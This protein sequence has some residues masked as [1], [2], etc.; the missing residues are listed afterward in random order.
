[1]QPF[2]GWWLW[3]GVSKAVQGVFN[4]TG[5]FEAAS[6]PDPAPKIILEEGYKDRL[7]AD[8]VVKLLI[9]NPELEKIIA[10]I[11]ETKT[12]VF[13][14]QNNI[15]NT[16]NSDVKGVHARIDHLD[17]NLRLELARNSAKFSSE[18]SRCCKR[19]FIHLE[20]YVKKLLV[21]LLGVPNHNQQD[22]LSW[23]HSIFVAKQD[24]ETRLNNVTISMNSNVEA[25]LESS[26]A[27]IMDKVTEKI[28]LMLKQR[29]QNI[30]MNQNI[31]LNSALSD[32]QVHR[33]VK[34]ALAMYDADKTGLVDYALEPSGGQ[35]LSTRCTE[36]YN[37]KTA[38]VSILGIPLWYPSNTPRV[39]ITPGVVPGQCWAF[40][41]FPGFL[42]IELSTYVKVSAFTL[43]HI[44]E[45]LAP[46]GVRDSA[47]KAF[48]VWGL[49]SE[50]DREPWQFGSYAYS[51]NDSSIQYFAVEN[52]APP[53]N[54][55]ELR[56][57]SNHGNL[58]Y[59]C[60]Y[61]FRVHGILSNETT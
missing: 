28:N 18:L 38:V 10:R 58:K 16:L 51:L 37:L 11:I 7:S 39:V 33:I 17:A 48:T 46:G 31:G 47:P 4:S 2:T 34:E 57:E 40:Q 44:P 12:T 35:I 5:Y 22:I 24:L 54:L 1:M 13:Q 45:A 14:E 3:S 42:L 26:A 21:D 53:V 32:S 60:L 20:T 27:R 8:D 56:I 19:Q 25:M 49:K 15:L 55:V 30:E 6:I 43:E 50:K 52:D 41:N 29:M 61:R 9:S 36:N 59:T 23:L